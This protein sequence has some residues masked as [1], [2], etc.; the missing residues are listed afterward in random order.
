MSYIV[1]RI[2]ETRSIDFEPVIWHGYISMLRSRDKGALRKFMQGMLN[3]LDFTIY[4]L[5][6]VS[7]DSKEVA[8]D[9]Y[10]YDALGRFLINL[11]R[12][13]R[14]LLN[15]IEKKTG[16]RPKL[17]KEVYEAYSECIKNSKNMA[18]F[19]AGARLCLRMLITAAR[20]GF[21]YANDKEL[22]MVLLMMIERDNDYNLYM[23]EFLGRFVGEPDVYEPSL[24]V[25]NIV[26]DLCM[27][28]FPHEPAEIAEPIKWVDVCGVEELNEKSIKRVLIDG[29]IELLLVKTLGKIYAIEN[30]CSHEGGYLS[31]GILESYSISCID[32][33]AKFDVRSGR[34]LTHPHHGLA[35]PQA[36][37]PTKIENSRILIG[38]YI[39]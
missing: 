13:R 36:T 11:T 31:D 27:R 22:R 32:H 3:M 26:L 16:E 34:V 6:R 14:Y 8:E 35:R 19:I 39:E 30:I 4:C 7:S 9:P 15:V 10:I 5:M 37:F 12:H 21:Y 29:W 1:T 25:A 23:D 17:V 18:D 24:D 33:L 20:A 2:T 38:L 28:N